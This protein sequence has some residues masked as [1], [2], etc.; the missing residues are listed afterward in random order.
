MINTIAVC[1]EIDK[2]RKIDI[3]IDRLSNLNVEYNKIFLN[4][5][6]FIGS[7]VWEDQFKNSRIYG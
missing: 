4:V 2:H 3:Q 6:L 7:G 5:W 1:P